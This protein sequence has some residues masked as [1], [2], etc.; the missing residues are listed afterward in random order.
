MVFGVLEKDDKY[1]SIPEASMRARV[2]VHQLG[3]FVGECVCFLFVRECVSSLSVC[4]CMCV[5]HHVRQRLF[6]LVSVF[7]SFV[8]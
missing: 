4:V 5:R 2:C 8:N 1:A 3:V 7:V 6:S